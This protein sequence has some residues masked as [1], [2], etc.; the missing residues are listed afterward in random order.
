MQDINRYGRLLE[1]ATNKTRT[2][3]EGDRRIPAGS[4]VRIL[5]I[6][7]PRDR[8]SIY[9]A[10]PGSRR[11]LIQREGDGALWTA[12]SNV[13]LIEQSPLTSPLGPVL[14]NFRV[15]VRASLAAG[16]RDVSTTYKGITHNG[17]VQGKSAQ[18]YI[19]TV[20]SNG[21]LVTLDFNRELSRHQFH[22]MSIA[23]AEMIRDLLDVAIRDAQEVQQ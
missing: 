11:V 19:D 17:L 23:D 20:A 4:A 7:D 13:E 9:S 14:E 5:D 21:P 2:N 18:S 6:I 3:P 8:A 12:A 15:R 1:D 22:D 10:G 16:S